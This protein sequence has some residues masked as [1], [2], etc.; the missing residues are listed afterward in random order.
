MTLAHSPLIEL[1]RKLGRRTSVQSCFPFSAAS[2]PYPLQ[3][4]I[5]VTLF[6]PVLATQDSF[7]VSQLTSI[8][9]HKRSPRT[10]VV[11]P[12][13]FSSSQNMLLNYKCLPG[14][15]FFP[16]VVDSSHAN[17]NMHG[18]GPQFC[19]LLKTN[20]CG[21][22]IACCASAFRSVQILIRTERILRSSK[23]KKNL[24]H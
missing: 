14:K 2:E 8:R 18:K 12:R 5:P 23:G 24:T 3:L 13:T 20:F 7:V 22:I 11:S 6:D 9:G 10:V 15:C 19:G 1:S 4:A 17:V 21:C 16:I